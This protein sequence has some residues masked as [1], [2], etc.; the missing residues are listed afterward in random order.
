MMRNFQQKKKWRAILESRPMLA[1]LLLVVLIFAWNVFG[2]WQKMEDTERNK[3][4]AEDKIISLRQEKEKL[5]ADIAKLN[6]PEGME[7]S[8]REKFGLVKDGEG[9]IVV[10]DD[11][12]PP[13]EEKKYE[14]NKFFS[15]LKNLFK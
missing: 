5:T 4:I 3:K 7:A 1:L 8:I 10:V 13:V 15:F 9:L 11:Q 6:T 14:D 12:N 2:L